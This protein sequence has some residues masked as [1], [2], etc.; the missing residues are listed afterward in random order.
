MPLFEVVILEHP[1]PKAAEAGEVEKLV[2]GPTPIVAPDAQSA[3]I[4]AVM[5]DPTKLAEVN[6]SRMQVIIR[7]FQ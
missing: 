2:F 6:K 7:P 3:A 5:G 4:A 1:T